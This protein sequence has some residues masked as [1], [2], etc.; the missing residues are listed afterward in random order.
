ME[1]LRSSKKRI[2]GLKQTLKAIKNGTVNIVY[3]ANDADEPI[4]N[5]ILEECRGKDIE[6]V[7]IDTMKKLGEACGI[8][9]N[10]SCASILKG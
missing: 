8:D 4:K 10:A 5:S 9:V 7:Q 2:I 6:I 1:R 3:L